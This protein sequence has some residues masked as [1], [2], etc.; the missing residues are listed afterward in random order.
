MTEQLIDLFDLLDLLKNSISPSPSQDIYMVTELMDCDLDQLIRDTRKPIEAQ[1]V[2]SFT[3][4]ILMGLKFMHAGHVIHRDLK[5]ANIFVRKDG[6]IK[7]GDLG[8]VRLTIGP[9]VIL[10]YTTFFWPRK[11]GLHFLGQENPAH[12]FLAKK[13]W[14]TF[15]WPRKSGPHFLG[16]ENVGNISL[17]K[18]I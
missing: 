16:Q 14:L 9:T 11:C 17:A 13:I 5:P 12:I 6:R 4:Q 8:L 7:L 3:Y 1:L 10:M 2:R 15:S 18:K